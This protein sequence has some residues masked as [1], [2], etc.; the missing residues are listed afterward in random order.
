MG[1]R[2]GLLR[3][4][5]PAGR[6]G[7]TTVRVSV[8]VPLAG[9]A[10]AIRTSDLAVGS[11]VAVGLLLAAACTEAVRCV[12]SARLG[13]PVRDLLLWPLGGLE[14][15]EATPTRP[16]W[17]HLC[18]P[19][20]GL[21]VCGALWGVVRSL[22]APV[23]LEPEPTIAAAFLLS[24][25]VVTGANLLPAWPLASGRAVRDFWADRSGPHAADL[26]A[27]GLTHLIGVLWLF[28]AVAIGSAWVAA[29]AAAVMLAARERRQRPRPAPRPRENDTFLGYD[30]SAGYTSLE[31]DETDESSA[32]S[33][34]DEFETAAYEQAAAAPGSLADWRRQREEARRERERDEQ[35][36]EA[37]EVDRLLRKI[38]AEGERALTA[39]ERRTLTRAAARLRQGPAG[40]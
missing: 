2:D 20:S 8:L 3:W 24:A 10:A 22:G 30:F 11:A 25:A 6:W 39:A 26:A 15:P 17:V 35:R 27:A 40:S 7:G 21:V 32:A 16:P 4:T 13:A 36:R 1:F 12:V 18:V 38:S 14:S 34:Q 19:A 29:A 28:L 9:I 31:R 37:L 23:A 33:G 5:I